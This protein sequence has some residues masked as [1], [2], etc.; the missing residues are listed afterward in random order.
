MTRAK[1][2]KSR[3]E[4]RARDVQRR[5][6]FGAVL[7]AHLMLPGFVR[8]QS[9][10]VTLGNAPEATGKPGDYVTLGFMAAGAGSLNFELSGPDG[11]TLVSKSRTVELE[12]EPSLVAF[13]LR[14]PE[15]AVADSK[16]EFVLRA[17]QDGATLAEARGVVVVQRL[18][19]LEFRGPEEVFGR[20]GSPT[21]FEMLVTNRGNATDTFVI[22]AV[23]SVW[24]VAFDPPTVT[25]EPG[26]SRAVRGTL[27]QEGTISSGFFYY[28]RL[29]A[30]A[31][32]SPEVSQETALEVRFSPR[33]DPSQGEGSELQLTASVGFAATA[34]ASFEGDKSSFAAGYS[35]SASVAGP[36]SDYATG[37]VTP[38]SISGDV[39]TPFRA[40]SDIRF[41]VKAKNWDASLGVSSTGANA[42]VNFDLWQLRWGTNLSFSSQAGGARSNLDAGISARSQI[43]GL[44]F[45]VSASSRTVFGLNPGRSDNLGVQSQWR[46]AENLGLNLN[47]FVFGSSSETVP[48][49]LGFNL[50]QSLAW[51][52]QDL[53]LLE[54]LSGTPLA[55]AYNVALFGSSRSLQ[56][57]AIT[58]GSSLSLTNANG[59]PGQV[60]QGG[61]NSNLAVNAAL[62]DF[63]FGTSLSHQYSVSGPA[64]SQRSSSWSVSPGIGYSFRFLPITGSA[65]LGLNYTGVLLG[66]QAASTGAGFGLNLNWAPFSLGLTLGWRGVAPSSG[67]S[68][69]LAGENTTTFGAQASLPVL[70]GQIRG[71]YNYTFKLT[72]T[73]LETHA[74]GLE[75][76][77]PWTSDF[78]TRLNFSSNTVRT[79][80]LTVGT[81][82]SL[83]VNFSFRNVLVDNLSFNFGYSFSSPNGLFGGSSDAGVP[84]RHDL[85]FGLGYA[86][87]VRFATPGFL[88]DL[89]GGRESGELFGTAFMDSNLNGKRDADEAPLAGLVIQLGK[90]RVTTDALG[91]Y[92]L[93]APVGTNSLEFPGGLAANIDLIAERSEE[94]R[95]NESRQ[96]DLPFNLVSS[97]PVML[98]DDLNHNGS[99]EANEPGI[100]YGG[101]IVEGPVRKRIQV[102]ADGTASISGLVSGTYTIQ[103]DNE[104]LPTDY[105]ALGSVISFSIDAPNAANEVVLSAALPL[106]AVVTTFSSSDL[107]ILASTPNS[108]L[109]A[110]AEVRLD[111]QAQGDAKSVTAAFAGQQVKL[112]GR[113]GLWIGILRLP[114]NTPIGEATIEITAT[115]AGSSGAGS[116]GAGSSGAGSNGA[117]SNA[118]VRSEITIN[119]VPGLLFTIKDSRAEVGIPAMLEIQTLYRPTQAPELRLPNGRLVAFESSDG[120]VWRTNF[121]SPA[122]P[123]KQT[124]VLLEAGRELGPVTMTFEAAVG[125][126]GAAPVSS[127]NGSVATSSTSESSPATSPSTSSPATSST[128]ASSSPVASSSEPA[129]VTSSN[130]TNGLRATASASVKI[131]ISEPWPNRNRVEEVIP[132]PIAPEETGLEVA[133]ETPESIIEDPMIVFFA[134]EPQTFPVIELNFEDTGGSVNEPKPEPAPSEPSP[135]PSPGNPSPGNPSPGNP[136]MQILLPDHFENDTPDQFNLRF[137]YRSRIGR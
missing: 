98:F 133:Q 4:S 51:R 6:A 24:R 105:R 72:D 115:G 44:N 70:N 82:Q 108:S 80:G 43:P 135:T 109:P 86:F 68:S 34:N 69:Q 37:S 123:G 64:D 22:E 118:K 90:A 32:A 29:R 127:L 92:R 46:L 47:G 8:A 126:T 67:S 9:S 74:F 84:S 15:R 97:L 132:K 19:R 31:S 112:E 104:K 122:I 116:S 14:V 87:D 33:R 56:P 40:P 54:S 12:A 53:E 60:L 39:Q 1:A 50:S 16:N 3:V 49:Q 81:P 13:T 66:S 71:K 28:V 111:V 57:L 85:S 101:L 10:T 73:L 137:S 48:Y 65:S 129:P 114:E 96:R 95:L 21:S 124:M 45:S 100:P 36:L 42:G 62:G 94:I 128:V 91:Q 17:V 7:T 119:V 5:V 38:G 25:L 117:G 61:I 11:W 121:E 63:S 2:S 99:R 52:S 88:I 41:G 26:A 23:D 35:A 120:Y 77:Q 125:T 55:G 75:W 131:T 58:A 134:L 107:A 89:A 78:S 110:G 59:A 20:P 79:N 27:Y 83:G 136:S 76:E 102:S 103:A 130:F 18:S 106:R 93:R 30:T 113:D